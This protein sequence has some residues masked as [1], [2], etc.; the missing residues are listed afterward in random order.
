M[1]ILAYFLSVIVL[2][3]LVVAPTRA[4]TDY[5][6]DLTKKL[7]AVFAECQTIKPGMTRAELAKLFKEDTGGVAWPSSKPFPFQ[8]HMTFDYRKCNL[9]KIDI[10]FAP[11]DFKY[12]Q[13]TDIITKIS[14]PYIDNRP[15]V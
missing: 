5:D 6:A 11:T 9:I 10:D 1:K 2:L 12:A 3:G 4:G 8:Q 13:S 7:G 14:K 15:R